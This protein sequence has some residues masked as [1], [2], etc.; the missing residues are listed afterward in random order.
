MP[1][2]RSPSVPPGVMVVEVSGFRIVERGKHSCQ[3]ADTMVL[4]RLSR[5][6]REASGQAES[7]NTAALQAAIFL[8]AS[9]A[10]CGPAVTNGPRL[11]ANQSLMRLSIVDRTTCVDVRWACL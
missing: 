5:A 1:S 10:Y 9:E 3:S 4:L 8:T 11:T 2:G 6:D 7:S